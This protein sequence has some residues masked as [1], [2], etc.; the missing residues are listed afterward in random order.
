LVDGC[1][2]CQRPSGSVAGQTDE[3]RRELLVDDLHDDRLLGVGVAG[4]GLG[5][6]PI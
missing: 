3:A 2:A 5:G 6:D 1:V 4:L